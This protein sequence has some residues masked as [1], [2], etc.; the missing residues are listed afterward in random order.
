M[1]RFTFF[2]LIYLLTGCLGEGSKATSKLELNVDAVNFC[3]RVVGESFMWNDLQIRNTGKGPLTIRSIKIRGDAGCAFQC[4]YN[5]GNGIAKCP[6]ESSSSK[7]TSVTVAD[8]DT[9]LVRVIYT[10]STEDEADKA[11]LVITSDADNLGE[12]DV[13]WPVALVPM[14]GQGVGAAD[15]EGDAGAPL[16]DAGP[17]ECGDC[18]GPQKKSAPGCEE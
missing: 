4:S 11:T 18:G 16:V 8:G 10:P 7:A 2:I 14:C 15:T 17:E 1:K 5:S 6:R 13:E 9:L 3:D 12:D